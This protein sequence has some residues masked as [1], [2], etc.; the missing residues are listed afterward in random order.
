MSDYL[1]YQIFVSANK[2]SKY[3]AIFALYKF[4]KQEILSIDEKVTLAARQ[5]VKRE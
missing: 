5:L 4:K 2:K 3:I 1:T